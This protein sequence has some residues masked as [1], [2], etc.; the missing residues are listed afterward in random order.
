V[1]AE[2]ALRIGLVADVVDG[3]RLAERALEAA[4]QIAAL[5]PWGVRL[6]KQGMWDALESSSG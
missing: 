5:A 3:D 4:A 2:E 6:T 1:Y